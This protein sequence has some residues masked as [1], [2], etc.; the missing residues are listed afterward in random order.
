MEAAGFP[1]KL[2][3]PGSNLLAVHSI[4]SGMLEILFCVKSIL[5]RCVIIPMLAGSEVSLLQA[6]LRTSSDLRLLNSVHT[7]RFQLIAH[8]LQMH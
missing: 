5:L 2:L 4:P 1:G 8:T 3:N 6:T 7:Q